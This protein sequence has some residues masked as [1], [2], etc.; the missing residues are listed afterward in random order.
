MFSAA[1]S[2]E[3]WCLACASVSRRRRR[4]RPHGPAPAVGSVSPAATSLLRLP[5]TERQGCEPAEAVAKDRRGCSDGLSGPLGR[6]S[7]PQQ[8]ALLSCPH[9]GAA[10][11]H[12]LALCSPLGRLVQEALLS[13]C[14]ALTHACLREPRRVWSLT[15]PY[16]AITWPDFDTLVS[17]GTGRPQRGSSWPVEPL[18][19]MSPT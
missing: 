1:A 4:L 7:H 16:R 18:G 11:P 3:A 5:R 17:Q 13:A 10:F 14:P 8:A 9:P 15:G 12:G 19:H 6:S 2:S